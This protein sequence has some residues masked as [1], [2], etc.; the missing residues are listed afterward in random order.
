MGVQL[1]IFHGNKLLCP[2]MFVSINN[3]PDQEGAIPI[4]QSVQFDILVSNLPRMAKLCVGIF[5]KKKGSINPIF[6]VNTNIFD[7]KARLKWKATRKATYNILSS[8]WKSYTRPL[9][10]SP[11]V[12]LFGRRL[13]AN[14]PNPFT[15]ETSHLQP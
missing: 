3:S 6:F 15:S 2:T 4:Q 11:F 12:E 13:H 9:S 5:E 7:Y 1:G 14:L 8:N 10:N